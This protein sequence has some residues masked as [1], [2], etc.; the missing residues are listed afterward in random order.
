M[1]SVSAQ[2]IPET[3]FKAAVQG[4]FDETLPVAMEMTDT[5]SA[6]VAVVKGGEVIHAS[7]YGKANIE[8]SQNTTANHLFRIGSVSKLFTWTAIMQLYE[9]GQLD[10]DTDINQYLKNIQIPD[11][12]DQP[13]T[14]K[15]LLTH[16]PGYEDG[17]WG[18]L[19]LFDIDKALTLEQAM[20]KHMPERINPP[21]KHAS[22]SNYGT[23]LAGLIIENV[24]GQS[25]NDYIKA[26]IFKPLAMNQSTFIEPLPDDLAPHMTQAYGRSMGVFSPKPF[27][28]ITG[29]GPAGSMASS[30]HDMSRF[31][32]AHLNDG[33]LDGQR[34]LKA[35][36]AQLMHSTLFQADKRLNGMAHGFYEITANGH[37]LIG[38][39]GD[40]TQFHTALFLDKDKQLGGYISIM[41]TNDA[42]VR[43]HFVQSFYDRFY[44]AE[45]AVVTP[46][47]DFAVRADHYTGRYQ[48]LRH[49]ESTIEKASIIFN[50]AAQVMLTD[51]NTLFI[52]G[53][54]FVEVDQHLF[55]QI[56]GEN[57]VAFT[58]NEQ[59]EITSFSLNSRP[60]TT[61]SR[62]PN[63]ES[64]F[65]KKGLPILILLL[66]LHQFI[67]WIYQ[68]NSNK[69]LV[70]SQR[71]LILAGGLTAAT[72]LIFV[73]WFLLVA[74][75]YQL[76]FIEGIPQALA[77]SLFLP[78]VAAGLTAVTLVAYI[79]RWTSGDWIIRSRL[80]WLIFIAAAAFMVWYYHHWQLMGWNYA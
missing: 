68:R 71:H 54:Q 18:F 44:P 29:F 60:H 26:H 15:H 47:A 21:G 5:L 20:T 78:Y 33:E 76:T 64:S 62:I 10:L 41:N 34:I 74:L 40:T 7:G 55:Q 65:Y 27:E 35:E 24:S 38:H 31:M 19:I 67:A 14:L 50:D 58:E 22:Y 4:Y 45:N 25:F 49:N 53:K 8:Q 16:T 61:F 80:Y 75:S 66:F 12:F 1:I 13:I 32:M 11:T 28:I 59:G 56:D 3:I 73:V 2:E 9:Q 48:S 69:K 77:S 39:N 51:E 42:G 72:N 70:S 17:W 36:T 6:T 23:A 79:K 43:N 30:A 46:P 63:S 37:R 52:L 57:K